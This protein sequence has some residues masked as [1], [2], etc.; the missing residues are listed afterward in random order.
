[1]ETRPL[2][3]LAAL[4][5]LAFAVTLL[6]RSTGQLESLELKAYDSYL[7]LAGG[8]SEAREPIVMVEYTERDEAAFGYPLPDDILGRLLEQ[9][10]ADK[11]IAIGLDLIRDR[12]E[13][14]SADRA[15][16]ES[17]SK[18]FRQHPSIIGIVKE[19]S[20]GFGPP[21]A[22]EDKP[23][24]VGSAALL[25]GPDGV[26]RRGLLQISDGKGTTRPSLAFMLASRY[27]A[28]NDIRMERSWDS[29]L[30]L[31]ESTIRPFNPESSGFYRHPAERAG[32]YQ[33]LLTFPA[34]TA[35]FERHDVSDVLDNPDRLDVSNRIVLIGNTVWAAK[36]VVNVPLRCD[37]TV[38]GKMYGVHLHGQIVSQLI[39]QAKGMLH[40]IENTAQRFGNPTLSTIF[41]GGWI[42]LWTV[43]GG[44]TVMLVTSRLW[45]IAGACAACIAMV[46]LNG[47]AFT[48]FHWWLPVVPSATGF[49]LALTLTVIYLMTR[50]ES[51]R[52]HIMTLFSGVVSKRVADAIWRRRHEAEDKPLQLMTATAM[53]S[54]IKGFTTISEHLPEPVLADWLNDYISVMVDIVAAHGGVIEK[55][56]GD[57]LTVA[58]GVP[59]ARTTEEEIDMD[60]RAAVDCALAMARN[61]PQL[62]AAWEEKKLPSIG[63]RIGIHTGPLMV[64]MIG[65]ADRWQYSIVGDT[66][67][68]AA[69]LESYAKDDPEL[70]CDVG[71]CRILISQAS[72]DHLNDDYNAEIIGMANLKGKSEMIGVHRVLG[73][74]ASKPEWSMEMKG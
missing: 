65:S 24:Q 21:P 8:Q 33:V 53:F 46:V 37:G 74:R 12:Q 49:A 51:E 55:F 68:T 61:L 64:G 26:I 3:S 59:E 52:E 56:A 6:M 40:P 20:G 39:G 71:H 70:G 66:A 18:T 2:I 27:M 72:F 5:L 15:A 19:G 9:L 47:L 63:V 58:F 50:A 48:V 36:D 35:G 11:P 16:F 25:P 28:I 67:N 4:A 62:N 54:D 23:L 41:D 69:R 43:S 29:P 38:D 31:G 13:P 44:L 42:W 22:L 73:H 34:C 14:P 57:G 7:R 1:M 32:G 30:T 17:L 10:A 45:L 60:A